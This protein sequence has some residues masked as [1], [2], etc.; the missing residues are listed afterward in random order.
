MNKRQKRNIATLANQYGRQ[1]FSTA[2]R[3]LG[4]S[5]HAE[6]VVQD[7]YMKLF[8][9]APKA[10]DK[11]KNWPAY[12][13]T[14]AASTSLDLLRKK[15]RLSENSISDINLSTSE[16]TDADLPEKQVSLQQDL[17]QL[18]KALTHVTARESEVFVLRFVEEFTYQEIADQLGIT[19]S[20]V[21][22]IV[23]RT[24]QKLAELIVNQQHSG[25]K[26]EI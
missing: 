11:V 10:F 21:G 23:N 4:D 2:Y 22:I 26:H 17:H 24:R 18:R 7:V 19:V 14:M 16:N 20:N 9:K 5:H 8:K 3:I 6:D 13:T 1:V 12:L 15:C 25:D